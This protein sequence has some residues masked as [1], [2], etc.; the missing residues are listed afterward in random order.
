MQVGEIANLANQTLAALIFLH[1]QGVM[2]RDIK[3]GNILCVAQNHY[4]L[5]D[6]GV[7]KDVAPSLLSKQ[8]TAEY[9]APEVHDL[10]PY[11]YP[12]DMW[13]LG[14]VLFECMEALPDGRPGADGRKWCERV[15]SKFILYYDR[16]IKRPPY[17]KGKETIE[18]I[19]FIKEAL[20]HMDP[21][22]R[23]SARECVENYHHLLENVGD[24]EDWDTGIGAKTPTQA[25][26]SGS[27]PPASLNTSEDD[28]AGEESSS[29]VRW[30]GEG[31]PEEG[32]EPRDFQN[33][34]KSAVTTHSSAGTSFRGSF[35]QSPPSFG[36]GPI[37]NP[38]RDILDFP[39]IA[40]GTTYDPGVAHLPS[41]GT[42][43]L[44]DPAH[45]F[46]SVPSM[47]ETGTLTRSISE[48]SIKRR[49]DSNT[50]SEGDENDGSVTSSRRASYRP[51]NEVAA[52]G[53]GD[54]LVSHPS[55]VRI[56]SSTQSHKRS[57]SAA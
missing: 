53:S 11:S 19:L 57:K 27:F 29:T 5:A 18:L 55:V 35:F 8:G 15:F 7:S 33:E 48:G 46:A 39:S 37:S 17:W 24:G 4:K 28:E 22:E 21:D 10:A 16:N 54:G 32:R 6:F 2:H 26:P 13:S 9:M 12:A 49:R 47:S 30:N 41:V 52:A 44:Y 3:P 56:T 40:E 36:G 42:G 38:S 1:D 45:V 14:V 31:T 25:H 20:L 50:S 43:I 23:L 34:D 51:G